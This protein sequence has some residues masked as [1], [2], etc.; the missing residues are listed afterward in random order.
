MSSRIQFENWGPGTER[1][2]RDAFAAGTMWPVTRGALAALVDLGMSN[3]T[4]AE[5][6]RVRPDEVSDLRA[7]YGV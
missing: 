7:D 6:F 4:I 5:Y 2:L 3:V 1:T